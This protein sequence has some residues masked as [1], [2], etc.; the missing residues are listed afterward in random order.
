MNSVEL[1]VL[2]VSLGDVCTLVQHPATMTHASYTHQQLE[3]AGITE[4]LVRLSVGLEDVDD[5]M[6]DLDQAL[7]KV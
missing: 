7:K 1:C 6:Y 3:H 4:G 2:A 5:I